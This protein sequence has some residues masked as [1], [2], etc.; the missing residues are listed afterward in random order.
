MPNLRAASLLSGALLPSLCTA[1]TVTLER[2]AYFKEQQWQRNADLLFQSLPVWSIT[3]NLIAATIL[4]AVW[5]QQRGFTHFSWLFGASL[6]GTVWT[7]PM[8]FPA[9]FP[10]LAVQ[11]GVLA[12]MYCLVRILIPQPNSAEKKALG[13]LF[14]VGLLMY[15]AGLALDVPHAHDLLTALYS[16]ALLLVC[17]VRWRRFLKSGRTLLLAVWLLAASGCVDAGIR[18]LDWHLATFPQQ[19]PSLMPLIQMLAVVLVLSFLVTRHAEN[20]KALIQLNASLDQRVQAAETELDTRYRNMTQDALEA[21]AMR[22]RSQIYESIHEDL[23]DKL[24]Q[25]IYGASK[26]NTA[27]LAR[28]ALAELRDSRRLQTDSKRALPEVL[29]DLYAEC[30]SRCELAFLPLDWTCSDALKPLRLNARQ[31]SALSRSLREALSNLLKHAQA[32]KV[33]IQFEKTPGSLRYRVHDNGVGMATSESRGRGL[34]NMHQRLQELGGSLRVDSSSA[35]TTLHFE[36]PV[37]EDAA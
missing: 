19:V 18:V 28:A 11:A 3:V 26:P 17:T 32:T 34:I 10:A 35:G 27:D 7:L 22:E 20:Q 23:S 36:L 4:F 29:A 14:P 33:S 37:Q 15:G 2:Q 21:A 8:L 6:L 24:L 25:L 9:L 16:L 1:A 12:W 13:I 31:E 30:Q 5:R